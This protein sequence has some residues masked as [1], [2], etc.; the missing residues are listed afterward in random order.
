M[1]WPNDADG[2]VFRQLKAHD[3]DFQQPCVVHFNVD[4]DDWPPAPD[5]LELL[6]ELYDDVTLIE[7]D[8]QDLAEGAEAGYVQIQIEELLSY[9]FV[10]ELQV[11]ITRQL[12]AFA[13]R[14]NSWG[15]SQ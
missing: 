15:V 1:Q 14:C 8:E 9:E 13:A 6:D 12:Q 7:A 5:A 3:F 2:D 10:V 11:Q 4:F